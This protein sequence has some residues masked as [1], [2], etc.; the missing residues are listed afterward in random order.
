MKEWEENFATNII[1]KKNLDVG[2]WW[3]ILL[4]IFMNFV[5]IVISFRKLE[6]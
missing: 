2:Y 5:E 3:P 4:K 1:T 6:D